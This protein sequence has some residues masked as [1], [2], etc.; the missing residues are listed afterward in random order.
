[1]PTFSGLIEVDP[2]HGDISKLP[3]WNRGHLILEKIFELNLEKDFG[4]TDFNLQRF[5][6]GKCQIQAKADFE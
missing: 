5:I 2:H 6:N 1:M 3:P 4:L